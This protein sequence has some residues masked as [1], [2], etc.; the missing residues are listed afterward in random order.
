MATQIII[1]Q[2]GPLPIS[3]QFQAPTD[4]PADLFVAGSVWTKQANNML[5]IT[6]LLDGQKVAVAPI[7]ANPT[8]THLSV[9]PSIVPVTLTQGNHTLQLV[10]GTS[11]TISDS[12]DFYTVVLMY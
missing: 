6:V 7:Y 1:S 5:A 2:A 10:A 11:A 12:N 9:V 8:A 4:G 3:T